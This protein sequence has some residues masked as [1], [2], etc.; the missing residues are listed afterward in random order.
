LTLVAPEFRPTLGDEIQ[1]LRPRW[2]MPVTVLLIAI[3]AA[4]LVLIRMNRQS[5]ALGSNAAPE[6]RSQL[7]WR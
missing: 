4:A 6:T 1:R 2:R 7:A 3:A 5:S